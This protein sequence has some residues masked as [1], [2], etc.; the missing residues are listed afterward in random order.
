MFFPLLK[1]TFDIFHIHLKPPKNQKFFAN[2]LI[3]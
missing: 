2:K 3:C 1:K